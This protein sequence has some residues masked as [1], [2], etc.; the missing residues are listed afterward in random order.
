MTDTT[1]CSSHRTC[2][3]PA[4][5]LDLSLRNN[6]YNIRRTSITSESSPVNVCM[7]DGR[8]EGNSVWRHLTGR[9][10]EQNFSSDHGALEMVPTLD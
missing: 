3:L 2:S 1:Q 9:H 10:G 7:A 5:H 8:T 4:F 6:D